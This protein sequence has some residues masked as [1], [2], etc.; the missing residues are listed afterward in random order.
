MRDEILKLLENGKALDFFEISKALG[1]TKEMD[2]LLASKLTEMVNS[3]D[4]HITNKGRYM[5]F[6]D[7]EKMIIIS[8][9]NSWIL[10][11]LL[12]L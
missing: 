11:V 6:R 2:E 8:K 3:Y 5:L 9:V 7:N 10:M 12:V 4:L 1:Y